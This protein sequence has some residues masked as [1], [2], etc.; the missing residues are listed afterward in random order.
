MNWMLPKRKVHGSG[1][2]IELGRPDLKPQL[3]T[4]YDV[5]L[6]FYSNSIGLFTAG[7]FYKEIDDLIL[8]RTNRLIVND[9][10]DFGFTEAYRGYTVERA[11][12]NIF[13]TTVK[14]F[15]VEWQTHFHW[16]PKP[17]DGLLLN[18]NYSR[19]WSETNYPRTLVKQEQIP[20]PPFVISTVI[21]TFRTG[22]MP[23]QSADIA[24][25][26]IGYDKG[27]FSAR[28]SMLYQG[29]TLNDV[30]NRDLLDGFS[31][32]LLRWDLAVRV[33]FSEYF[34]VFWNLNNISNRSD[35]TYQKQ[36]EFLTYR[37]FYG[38]TMDLGVQFNL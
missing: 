21:D 8:Y 38:W 7:G 9:Y 16:L 6:S 17:F 11:E 27:P 37:E 19:I 3:S 22:R 10:E 13:E 24:N 34:F 25:L 20:Y 5:F 12:N 33:N 31:G 30:Q 15:E 4:N 28:L 26:A 23:D 32:D 14:G 18:V 2:E 29:N 1:R 36:S 35:D